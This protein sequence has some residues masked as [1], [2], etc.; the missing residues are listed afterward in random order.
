M[1]RHLSYLRYVIRHKFFVFIAG[2][3]YK[4]PFWRLIIHDWSKFL[5]SEW[6]PYAKTFYG[7]DGSSRY[8]EHPSF[9]RAWNHHQKRNK[10]HWQYWVTLRDD[11]GVR[12][13]KMPEKC[14]REMVA[15]W[16]G[17]GRAIHGT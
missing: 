2:L 10:H 12:A 6:T 9:G 5:P 8:K 4:A 7:S 11:G 14:V 3:H 1:K 17:A 15:D 16:A 13:V